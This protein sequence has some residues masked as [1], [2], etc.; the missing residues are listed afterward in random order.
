[1]MMI[2]STYSWKEVAILARDT[3]LLVYLALEKKDEEPKT[4]IEVSKRG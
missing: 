1:M 3:L 2:K 4:K